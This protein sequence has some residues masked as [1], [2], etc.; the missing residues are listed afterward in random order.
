M[1]QPPDTP[2]GSNRSTDFRLRSFRTQP[3]PLRRPKLRP[4]QHLN[5]TEENYPQHLTDKQRKRW[6]EAGKKAQQNLQL[7]Q[8][9]TPFRYS[10]S[11][12]NTPIFIHHLTL[13][14]T[15]EFIINTVRDITLYVI[16]TESDPPSALHL[17]P[18]PA[19]LQIQAI[20]SQENTILLLIEVQFLPHSS[21]RTFNLIQQLCNHIFSPQHHFV[22][23]DNVTNE[24]SPF[25]Q[26]SLFHLSNIQHYTNLQDYF[27]DTWNQTHLHISSCP[28][29]QNQ[30]QF[31][32]DSD[33]ELICYVDTHDLNDDFQP[34]NPSYTNL[35]CT[36]PDSIRPYK[37]SNASWSLQKAIHYT[38]NEA[39]DKSLTFNIWSCGLDPLLHTTSTTESTTT[40]EALTL[41]AINDVLAP[42]KLLF[43]LDHPIIVTWEPSSSTISNPI[44]DTSSSKLPAYFV[45]SDSHAK[46]IETLITTEYCTITTISIT[47]LKWFD[48]YD[49]QLCAYSLLQS[50]TFSSHLSTVSAI[51]LLIGTNFIY[52]IDVSQA[53]QQVA[54]TI[55]YLHQKYPHLNRKEHISIVATFPCHKPSSTFSSPSLSSNIEL[56]NDQL[57]TLSTNLNFTVVD[58]QVNDSHL[59][60][61][62]MHLHFNHRHIIYNFIINYF[63]E[64]SR[65]PSPPHC[66]HRRSSGAIR[67][68]NKFRHAQRKIKQQQFT[69]HRHIDTHWKPKHVKQ[70][71]KQHNVKYACLPEIR[72]HVL[73]IQFHNPVDRSHADQALPLDIFSE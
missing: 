46:H 30:V 52:Q 43:H 37:D 56:Y 13:H 36:C 65:R 45:F 7:I 40:R 62:Q 31:D 15:L 38:F 33:V 61:D 5:R 42:A 29:Q 1:M 67:R 57:V 58:F 8:Q 47:G 3:Y 6:L 25:Q 68:R 16:D 63:N 14:P 49:Q 50:S 32:S 71:L 73:Q 66:I 44:T 12:Q 28:V 17:E 22:A 11:Q 27:T 21:T 72:K 69:I 18:L 54:H 2:D 23:W 26:F 9:L 48:T 10:L 53:I 41:Y 59:A 35:P 20:K 24:L 70:L 51:M 39:L 19:L 4:Q 34:K 64:L 60:A 55:N